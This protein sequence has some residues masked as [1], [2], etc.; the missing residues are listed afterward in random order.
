M[1]V[2]DPTSLWTKRDHYIRDCFIAL[3]ILWFVWILLQL[4][5][6]LLNWNGLVPTTAA[7]QPAM[8]E[9]VGSTDAAHPTF[10]NQDTPA[11]TNSAKSP[12]LPLSS[13]LARAEALARNLFLT[14][15]WVLV[16]SAIGYG[17]T[18]GSMIVAWL[19]LVVALIWICVELIVPHPISRIGFGAVQFIFALTIMGVAFRFGW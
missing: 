15:L 3:W 1:A 17:V 10:E 7:S 13:N 4:G 19:Y 11:T 18:R 5:R 12:L 9:R 8:R 6:H 16:A 14:F 2:W